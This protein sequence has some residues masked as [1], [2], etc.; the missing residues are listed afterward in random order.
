MTAS[1]TLATMIDS[2][3]GKIVSVVFIKKDG[4][5]RNL[6][7]RLGVTKAL[8]GGV[9]QVDENKFITIFDMQKNDYRNINRDTIISIK[10]NG[11]EAIAA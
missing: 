5:Q 8:K 6:V 1:R 10:M 7:G 9:K 3:N 11:I 2:S 4:S